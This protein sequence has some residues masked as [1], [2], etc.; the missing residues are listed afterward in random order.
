[1]SGLTQFQL[2]LTQNA[3]EI[4]AKLQKEVLASILYSEEDENERGWRL[5]FNKED[6]QRHLIS[7]Y[8]QLNASD[9]DIRKKLDTTSAQSRAR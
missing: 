7:A 2:E 9:T 5:D 1:M 8:T 6:E 3:Q 4:A